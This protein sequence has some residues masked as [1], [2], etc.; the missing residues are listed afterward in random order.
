MQ[1]K[2]QKLTGLESNSL[3]NS[4]FG[5]QSMGLPS[6]NSH[7]EEVCIILN[8]FRNWKAQLIISI[9]CDI[10]RDGKRGYIHLNEKLKSI[11]ICQ[12]SHD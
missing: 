11:N 2:S 3:V 8:K 10:I 5:I 7:I 12:T 4:G 6:A 9:V 1:Q